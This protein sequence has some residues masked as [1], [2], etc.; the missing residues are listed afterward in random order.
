MAWLHLLPDYLVIPAVVV[1]LAAAVAAAP[2]IR[3]RLAPRKSPPPLNS[4]LMDAFIALASSA[5]VLLTFSLVQAEAVVRQVEDQVS[6]EAAALN[7]LDRTFTRYG[8]ARLTS[9]RQPLKAYGEAIVHGEWPLLHESGHST[10]ADALYAE[11]SKG[12]R[13]IEPETH[14]E[15]LMFAEALRQI[16]DLADLREER[17]DASRVTLPAIYWFT[18]LTM[19][20]LMIVIA[21]RNDPTRERT[22]IMATIATAIGL[23]TALVVIFDA[24]FQGSGSI[25]TEPF[26]QALEQ[27]AARH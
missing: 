8:D 9:L 16:D 23:L 3:H 1:P 13:A 18:T 10:D 6:K 12:L 26:L 19:I 15:Q 17:I 25:A 4:E 21:A 24:P 14:R 5:A 11:I 20:G 22:W 27:M 2:H 7:D